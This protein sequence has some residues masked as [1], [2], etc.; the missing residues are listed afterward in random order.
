MAVPDIS[1]RGV[2]VLVTR[3]AHQAETLVQKIEAAGGEAVRLPTIEILAPAST[4]ALH[5]ALDRLPEYSFA[6]FISPNAV[7]Q[8]LPLLRAHGGIPAGLRLASVGQGTQ[9][10]L[11]EEGFE[12]VLAPLD[13]FD[14]EA[15]LE[16]LPPTVV[17]GKNILIV[18][19][20]GGHKKLGESLN[21]RGARVTYAECYRRALPR[22]PDA[23]TLARVRRGEI[24]VLI[25]TSI[26]GARNLCILVGETDR[27]RLLAMPV[28]VV[29]ERLAQ[30]C[31]DL[32]F[33]GDL[34]VTAQASDAAIVSTL[35]AWRAR[36]KSL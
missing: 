7:Q 28:V 19:G 31:R 17:A 8:C 21:A 3:P 11:K 36:Q 10:A 6:I 13:R 2:R 30:T 1:L 35:Y 16:L 15:L 23:T 33:H 12:N 22:Q 26:E 25:L 29:S 18:R 14:S 24:D 20:E 34:S 9:R 4:V 32:G 5:A 27:A